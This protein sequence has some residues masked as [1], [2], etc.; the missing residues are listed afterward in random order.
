AHDVTGLADVV[1]DGATGLLAADGTG[2][3][4]ALGELAADAPRRRAMGE[5]A[6]LRVRQHFDLTSLASDSFAAYRRLGIA[7]APG[8]APSAV[9]SPRRTPARSGD[10]RIA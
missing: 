4:R 2:L 9:A 1:R 7:A 6:R 8:G 5:A 10:R 3:F